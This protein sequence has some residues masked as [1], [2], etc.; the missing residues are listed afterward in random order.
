[1]T[2]HEGRMRRDGHETWY[3]IVGELD[4]TAPQTPVVICHG[5]PGAAHDYTEPIADLARTGRACVLYDQLG[6]GKSDHLP[7]APADFW[8]PQLFK[9][10]LAALLRHLGIEERYAVVGQSFGKNHRQHA[11]Q[12]THHKY[13]HHRQQ[14]QR[15]QIHRRGRHTRTSFRF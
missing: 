14:P 8:S 13:Q 6:C 11:R 2:A 9:D 5:G 15:E 4:S 10:E 12:Q 3:R 7:D 1:M